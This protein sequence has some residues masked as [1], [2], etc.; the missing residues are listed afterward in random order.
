MLFIGST[1]NIEYLVMS[2]LKVRKV[3]YL[4]VWVV[5]VFYLAI[6]AQLF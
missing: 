3:E 2:Q 5:E 4:K 1:R 6:T